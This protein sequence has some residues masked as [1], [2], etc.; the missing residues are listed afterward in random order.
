MKK[1]LAV[2]FLIISLIVF[3]EVYTIKIGETQLGTSVFLKIDENTYRTITT[4]DY[5]MIYTIDSTTTYNG[6]WFKNYTA[7][8][9]I[10]GSFT[11]IINGINN[12]NKISF[13]FE[14]LTSSLTYD[15]SNG[16]FVVFDNNFV[17][18]HIQR[19]LEYP[20]PYFKIVIPQLLF[21]PSK[22]EYAIGDATL[23]KVDRNT[24][25][26]TY[27]NE[28]IRVNFENGKIMSLEYPGYVKVELKE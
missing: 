12:N 11:G 24:F 25:E 4:I 17:L 26:I 27:R 28:K 19:L 6:A 3:S 23:K 15:L 1:T 21:N 10:D 14:T 18:S 20:M 8:F 9:T 2:A 13:V 5:G 16:K 7:T 22:T